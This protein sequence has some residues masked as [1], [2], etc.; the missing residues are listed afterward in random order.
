M[1]IFKSQHSQL[2]DQLLNKRIPEIDKVIFSG[3][4]L[5]FPSKTN[6]EILWSVPF[7]PLRLP[8]TKI[9]P[10]GNENEKNK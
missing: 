3:P 4:T 1:N 9:S 7:N 5:F 10:S 6:M 8:F 2:Q